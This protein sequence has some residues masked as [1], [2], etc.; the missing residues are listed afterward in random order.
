LERLEATIRNREKAKL[1]HDYH[2]LKARLAELQQLDASGFRGETPAEQE[3]D[4]ILVLAAAKRLLENQRVKGKVEDKDVEE[5]I[6]DGTKGTSGDDG[7][8]SSK[9]NTTRPS[10]KKKESKWEYYPIDFDLDGELIGD[11]SKKKKAKKKATAAVAAATTTVAVVARPDKSSSGASKKRKR[12]DM[13][14]EYVLGDEEPEEEDEY[15]EGGSTV[16]YL[17]KAKAV[18]APR[19][20]LP[21]PKGPGFAVREK[22]KDEKASKLLDLAR[23]YNPRRPPRDVYPFGALLPELE[24]IDFDLPDWLGWSFDDQEDDVDALAE[25]PADPQTE[26]HP[27]ETDAMNVSGGEE[28]VHKEQEPP[29]TVE[30]ESAPT[31]GDGQT[32]DQED[33]SPRPFVLE[34][35]KTGSV[36][37]ALDD[38]E[39]SVLSELTDE[40]THMNQEATNSEQQQEEP[41][42]EEEEELEEEYAIL[43]SKRSRKSSGRSY[44]S[45]SKKARRR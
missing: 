36:F 45:K 37:V 33:S 17:K 1:A 28:V 3:K 43:K 15:V 2:H 13:E 27:E 38:A 34:T 8:S 25:R 35:R 21:I 23:K 11:S 16:A 40:E 29:T 12:D 24:V 42:E 32:S 20:S 39:S 9:A 6:E 26:D 7:V 4:K 41:V 30:E 22:E 14:M 31:S 44:S 19:R 18:P 5:G 10:K